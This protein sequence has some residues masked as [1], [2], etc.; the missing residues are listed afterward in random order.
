MRTWTIALAGAIALALVADVV[1]AQPPARKGPPGERAAK[2]RPG[3]PGGP[4]GRGPGR[5]FADRL[6]RA[7]DADGDGEISAEEIAGA[8]KALKKLDANGDG[9]LTRDELR[10]QFPGPRGPGGPGAEGF[11]QRLM[12]MDRN[13]DGKISKDELPERMQPMLERADANGDGVIDRK[14]AEQMAGQFGRGGPGGPG[15]NFV[16]RMMSLDRNGDGKVTKDEMP[17]WMQAR[18]LEQG[19][20]NGDGAIDKQE[21]EKMAEQFQRRGGGRGGR[22]QP[23]GRSP[24]RSEA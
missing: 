7:L 13:G 1:T 12:R 3:F 6:F 16:E 18:M 8:A 19:D 10:P 15:G 20:A 17:E 24:R 14:E 22:P 23:P 4:E 2:Q 21:A 5:G 11:V 9:K